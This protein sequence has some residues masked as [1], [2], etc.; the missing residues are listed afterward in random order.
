MKVHTRQIPVEGL[1]LEGE[2]NGIEFDTG[3]EYLKCLTPVRYSLDVGLSE[4][5]LFATGTLGI[6]LERQ[7]VN[8]L[9]KFEYPL[10]VNDFALQ[11]ELEGSETVDLTP[12]I[13][14]DILLNL[15]HYP[16]CDWDGQKVCNGAP[17][18]K[19]MAHQETAP[20]P[21]PAA[22]AWNELDKLKVKKKK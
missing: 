19:S 20:E 14:E 18:F 12:F 13:R 2:E 21:I 7:C 6:D 4:T 22:E 10:Q 5:G 3:D 8:C 11:T 17:G 15:P 1:H 16:H 9:E